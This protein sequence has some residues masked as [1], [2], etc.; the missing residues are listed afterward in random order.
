[1]DGSTAGLELLG[2]VFRPRVHREIYAFEDLPRAL[3]E[4]HEN[5]HDGLAVVRRFEPAPGAAHPDLGCN[6]ETYCGAR[7]LELEILGPTTVLA[8][9]DSVSLVEAW[10]VRPIG[11]GDDMATRDALVDALDAPAARTA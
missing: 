8:P 4:L 7:Y 9:G 1:M 6:V 2:R 3:R 11:A 10:E 5:R